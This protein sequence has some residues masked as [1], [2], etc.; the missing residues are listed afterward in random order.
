MARL[1]IAV[2][3]SVAV[4]ERLALLQAELPALVR[5]AVV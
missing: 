5:Q 1:F 4:V 3:L 2:D